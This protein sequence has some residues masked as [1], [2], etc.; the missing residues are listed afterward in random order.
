MI[1]VLKQR[2]INA[3]P[4]AV[5]QLLA[6]YMHDDEFCPL[7]V[8]VDP[9]TEGKDGMGS[10]RR[11]NFAN[12]T[13]I[14]EEVTA[15]EEGRSMRVLMSEM[16]SIPMKEAFAE[17]SI[18]PMTGGRTKVNWGLK[19]RA[20]YGPLGWLMGQTMMRMALGKVIMGNLEGLAEMVATPQTALA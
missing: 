12:G 5:W 19:F 7:V 16:G 3:K 11:N 9:L 1:H 4:D 20:K 10:K 8:S 15:W 6:D 14:V 2:T 13:S 18:E 17:I